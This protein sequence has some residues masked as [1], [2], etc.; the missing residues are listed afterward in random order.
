MSNIVLKSKTSGDLYGIVSENEEAVELQ[1]YTTGKKGVLSRDKVKEF[2]VFPVKINLMID[3]KPE[4]LNL[5]KRFCL[6]IEN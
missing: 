5:I 2:L 6:G 1:N 4:V 3:R